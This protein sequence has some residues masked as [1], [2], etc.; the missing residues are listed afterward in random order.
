MLG[1]SFMSEVTFEEIHKPN[2]PYTMDG[3]R[4]KVVGADLEGLVAAHN[5]ADLA[6]LLVLQQANLAS[7]AFLPL[8]RARVEAEQFCAPVYF[9]FRSYKV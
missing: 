3:E 2:K 9:A 7:P 6:R 1:W 5:E 4:T 8:V